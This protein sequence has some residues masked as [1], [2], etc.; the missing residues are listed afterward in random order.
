MLDFFSFS[1][2]LGIMFGVMAISSPRMPDLF[3]LLSFLFLLVPTMVAL[4]GGAPFVPTP[5]KACKRMMRVAGIK[6]DDNVVD[7]GCGDGRLAYLAANKHGAKATGYELSPLVYFLAKIRQLFWRSKAKIKFGDFRLC[8]LEGTDYIVCY[9]LPDT[10]RKFIP[11]FEK[12]LKK[13]AK[14]ISYAFHIEGWNPVHIEP[15]IPPENISK[16]WVYEIGK[17]YE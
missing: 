13:G 12:D 6:K 5:M 16:I 8:N 17:Q 9:M 14:I 1:V 15:S 3:M 4:I 7:I 11:K 2:I 10:L